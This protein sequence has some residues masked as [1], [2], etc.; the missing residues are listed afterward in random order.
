MSNVIESL[1]ALADDI[2]IDG[3]DR[4]DIRAA[5]GRI[6]SRRQDVARERERAKKYAAIV[7]ACRDARARF[8]EINKEF[9]D[10]NGQVAPTY[11]AER[12]AQMALDQHLRQAPSP[13]SY[14]GAAEL[15][16]F[17]AETEQLKRAIEN[18]Q[19]ACRDLNARKEALSRAL[20]AA[21]D[22]FARLAGEERALRPAEAA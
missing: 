7:P 17:A 21:R 3:E 15:K 22:E 18:A 14:P 1:Q 10:L 2:S 19:A 5:M 13:D 4:Q 20:L 8:E 9:A 6:I 12:R 11:G 16:K